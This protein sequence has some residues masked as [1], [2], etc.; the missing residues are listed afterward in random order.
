ML[1]LWL[2][3]C[4]PS[5]LQCSQVLGTGL[6]MDQFAGYHSMTCSLHFDELQFSV[7]AYLLQREV[8]LMRDKSYIYVCMCKKKYV[9]CSQGLYQYRKVVIV[10]SPL[11]SRMSLARGGLLGFQALFLSCWEGLNYNKRLLVTTRIHSPLFHS[12]W[13]LL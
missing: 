3:S 5:P 1:L 13:L 9:E 12:C 11:R 4:L 7:M 2:L 10:D 8:Y 6:Q